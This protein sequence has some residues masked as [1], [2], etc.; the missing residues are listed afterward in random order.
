MPVNVLS[1][2][3]WLA[4]T[5]AAGAAALSETESSAPP[6]RR[7][8]GQRPGQEMSEE[9]AVNQLKVMGITVGLGALRC[10]VESQ[11]VPGARAEAIALYPLAI[12]DFMHQLAFFCFVF[13]LH[14]THAHS[15]THTTTHNVTYAVLGTVVLLSAI[16]VVTTVVLMYFTF[17]KDSA[18]KAREAAEDA[19]R[20]EQNLKVIAK[21]RR[22]TQ[23]RRSL[24]T[25]A[26]KKI[27]LIRA[28]E[29]ST[30]ES[31]DAKEV[32]G[33]PEWRAALHT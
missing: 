22:K 3:V 21:I 4:A 25:R 24:M 7:L 2:V 11:S 26:T 14:R 8:D 17:K 29:S 5:T 28:L 27:T 23:Q 30:P 9:Q 16:A 15:P 31:E 12:D 20:E 33:I 13:T 10:V 6:R 1:A 32:G 19:L 18:R